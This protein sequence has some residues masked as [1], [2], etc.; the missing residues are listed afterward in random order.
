M[1][2]K[3]LGGGE[4]FQ[5]FSSEDSCLEH[6]MEVRFGLRHKCRKCGM[7]ST[8]HRLERRKAYSCAQCGHHLYPCAGT[9]FE[10]SRTPLRS[11]FRAIYLV[12]ASKHAISGKEL[13]RQLGVTYKCAY[14]M[15]Q[16]IRQMLAAGKAGGF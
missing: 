13:Q 7:Q 1:T 14:R 2:T 4:F 9:I 15:R 6:V 12:V 10:H 11:W 8:F 3:D 16:Q 5:R